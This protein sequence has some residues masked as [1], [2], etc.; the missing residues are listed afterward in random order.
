LN[1]C[2]SAADLFDVDLIRSRFAALDRPVTHIFVADSLNSK[3][4]KTPLISS[5]KSSTCYRRESCGISCLRRF[6]TAT[7]SN[8]R[9]SEWR[10]IN[11]IALL[12]RCLLFFTLCCLCER[13]TR[14]QC[15]RIHNAKVFIFRSKR[16]L[17][18]LRS[19]KHFQAIYHSV[20]VSVVPFLLAA[21]ASNY[22]TMRS[23]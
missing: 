18:A 1:A 23:N 16:F 11:R 19:S 9:P 20:N 17:R 7:K 21:S 3:R 15:Y 10:I 13:F 2:K 22:V 5:M 14:V 4:N 12:C 6:K 8:K